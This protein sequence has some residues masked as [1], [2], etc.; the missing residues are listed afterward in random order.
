MRY[1]RAKVLI[2]DKKELALVVRLLYAE[3]QVVMAYSLL[4][5]IQ[6]GEFGI[7]DFVVQKTDK[8]PTWNNIP[9]CGF[10]DIMGQF[11]KQGLL[12]DIEEVDDGKN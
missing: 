1:I 4:M 8:G 2:M 12:L 6:G 10:M 9:G 7:D 5:K 3:G 11:N